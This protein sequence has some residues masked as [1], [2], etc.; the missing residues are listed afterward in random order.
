MGEI[1]SIVQKYFLHCCF[2]FFFD[3]ISMKLIS[4]MYINYSGWF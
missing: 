4:Y 3:K 1:K 2:A